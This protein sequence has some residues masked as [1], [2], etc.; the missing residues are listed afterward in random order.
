VKALARLVDFLQAARGT[1]NRKTCTSL[2]GTLQHITFV[3]RDGQAYL[4]RFSTFLSKF[5]NNFT[6]L[7]LPSSVLH[8]LT[9]WRQVLSKPA[10]SRLLALQHDL[11]L[12]IWVDASTTWCIG[13]VVGNTWAAWQ[14][15]P[16]L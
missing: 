9:W 8:D 14:L 11:D 15:A 10:G 5:T 4:P 3:Y 2:N 13:L 1:V 16:G 6:L 12:D 7:H